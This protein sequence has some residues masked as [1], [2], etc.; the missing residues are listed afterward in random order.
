M[1]EKSNS[2]DAAIK[3]VTRRKTLNKR[4]PSRNQVRKRRDWIIVDSWRGNISKKSPSF[5][6]ASST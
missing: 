2:G 1:A 4:Q 5:R 3:S 6:V